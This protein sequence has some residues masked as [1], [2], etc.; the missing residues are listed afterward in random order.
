MVLRGISVVRNSDTEVLVSNN[1]RC[2]VLVRVAGSVG[3]EEKVIPASRP[4]NWHPS[5]V[6]A[7]PPGSSVT[8]YPEKEGPR[9]PAPERTGPFEFGGDEGNYHVFR[10]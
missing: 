9:G 10:V 4:A 1:R 3:S 7:C 6:V 8:V 5:V 2:R